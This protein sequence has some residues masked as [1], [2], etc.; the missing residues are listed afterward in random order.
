MS[1]CVFVFFLFE[2]H[3][4]MIIIYLAVWNNLRFP[5]SSFRPFSSIYRFTLPFFFGIKSPHN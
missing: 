1:F 5:R 4:C 2:R 3:L